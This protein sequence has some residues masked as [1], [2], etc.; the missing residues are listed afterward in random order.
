MNLF[1]E[2]GSHLSGL[3]QLRAMMESGWNAR[4]ASTSIT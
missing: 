3:E 4:P 2:I 1:A